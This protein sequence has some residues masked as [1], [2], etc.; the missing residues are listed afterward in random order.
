MGKIIKL[1]K[2]I[3]NEFKN[4]FFRLFYSKKIK[5]LINLIN[6]KNNNTII[7]LN[8]V[9]WDIP[10]FQRPHH[11]AHSL[12]KQEYTYIFFTGN[13]YDNVDIYEMENEN[14][15][16]VNK[17]FTKYVIKLLNTNKK[18]IHLY[19]TDMKTTNSDIDKFKTQ[20][21]EII[22]E[23]IDEIS[24]ELYGK[25]IPKKALEKHER[26]LKDK[27]VKLV[28]TARS[29]YNEANIKRNNANLKLV[30]NGVEYEH[31]SM[32]IKKNH[33]NKIFNNRDYIIGYFG[34]FASW[35]DYEL[36]EKL[37]NERPNYEIVLIG[38]DYDGSMDSSNLKNYEN[39]TVLGH[40]NYKK[41][42]NYAQYFNVS[43][44]PFVINDITESTSPIKLF[45]Y[46]ALGHPIVTTG[47]PECRLY[48][49]V[50]IGED[51]ADFIKKI[52]YA[53]TLQ[54]NEE[55][56]NIL[57]KEALENTWNSKAKDIIDLIK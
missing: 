44:I 19:S 11:I 55:Y 49:S 9:D 26:L 23:Y 37:A 5:Q 38:I 54:Y 36:I 30:S 46:M 52:D 40:I 3:K 21:Y 56:L 43:M 22:Y 32:D 33:S 35:F 1:I 15:Y 16:I 53:I 50:L 24:C 14:L 17:C 13:V 41:L 34:A 2:K 12:S 42:P 57:K 51:K 4:M 39:I 25:E 7:F 31:F 47:M 27:Q 6:Q 29:L 28:C 10:L 8:V 18:Y 20:N 45:E 48:E